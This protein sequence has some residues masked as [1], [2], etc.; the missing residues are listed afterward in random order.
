MITYPKSPEL[1]TGD[2]ECGKNRTYISYNGS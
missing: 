1:I 2:F